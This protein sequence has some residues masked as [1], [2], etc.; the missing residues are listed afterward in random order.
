MIKNLALQLSPN[1]WSCIPTSFAMVFGIPVQR[2]FDKLKHDGSEILFPGL[3]EPLC[4][5]SFHIQE[6]IDVG[7]TLGRYVLV[8]EKELYL[9]PADDQIKKVNPL[10]SFVTYMHHHP[11]VLMG[12]LP[13]GMRHAVAYYDRK[14]YDP[15]GQVLSD[16]DINILM[17]CPVV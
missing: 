4:R 14:Y 16:Y 11:C 10:L 5:R 3:E 15:C 1:R 6:M 7:Y 8:L 9:S 13:N 12:V 2:I 17:C